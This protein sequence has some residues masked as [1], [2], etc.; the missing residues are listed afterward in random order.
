[1]V[2]LDK[3]L[4]NTLKLK[5]SA[6]HLER[7]NDIIPFEGKNVF[8]IGGH[9]VL[10]SISLDALKAKK[11]I[12][13][14]Y[15]S[16]ASGKRYLPETKEY[17]QEIVIPIN[18][19]KEI[20]DIQRIDF[21]ILDGDVVDLQGFDN[22]FDMSISINTL[23]HIADLPGMLNTVKRIMI[24]GG[25]HISV[26]GPIWSGHVG[27]HINSVFDSVHNKY[28][29]MPNHI[30]FNAWDHLLLSPAEMYHNLL[31]NCSD[32]AAR[33]IVRQT[34]T[35]ERINRIWFDD[36]VRFFEMSG[37]EIVQLTEDWI[38]SPPDSVASALAE[39]YPYQKNF[40]T[41]AATVVLRKKE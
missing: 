26:W 13:C 1:M 11:W 40:S 14:D 34:Y 3:N 7:I 37:M 24:P 31:Q 6:R 18:K 10:R 12:C 33:E 9:N 22:K 35:S 25:Y 36:Y 17:L 38:V 29:N 39:K 4:V 41:S 23:E 32:Q 30:P 8:E 20:E 28:Y 19:A 2:Q 5:H 15:I 16:G 21:A 27:H